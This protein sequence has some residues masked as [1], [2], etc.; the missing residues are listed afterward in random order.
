MIER[1]EIA[2]IGGGMVGLACA[3]ALRER[4]LDVVLCDPGEARARTSYGNAGQPSRAVPQ[5]GAGGASG[6]GS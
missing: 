2:V 3:L 1:A 5:E 6:G 4:G